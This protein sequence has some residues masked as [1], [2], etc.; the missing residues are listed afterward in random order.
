M[1]QPNW[2]DWDSPGHC[3]N[4]HVPHRPNQFVV[5]G[6]CSIKILPVPDVPDKSD[7]P[8]SCYNYIF[9]LITDFFLIKNFPICNVCNNF[10]FF[11]FFISVEHLFQVLSLSNFHFQNFIYI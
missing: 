3:P 4:V 1:S 9:N 2:S 10:F 8:K 7:C 6:Q 11:F 5:V